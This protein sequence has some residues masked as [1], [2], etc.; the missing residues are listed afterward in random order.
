M[1][2]MTSMTS[3]TLLRLP[4]LAASLLALPGCLALDGHAER[5]F[6]AQEKAPASVVVE[7]RFLDVR[8]T[9]AEAGDVDV[10]A[11]VVL[12]TTGGNPTAEREIE[13]CLVRVEREGDV[14]YVRQ[15]T[16]GE[17]IGVSS[18]SGRGYVAVILPKGV[19]V[20]VTS[21]SGDVNLRGD[22]GAVPIAIDVASGDVDGAFSAGRLS[23]D[24]A[25]GDTRVAI[26]G[27]LAALECDT[28][29]GDID[30]KAPS[31]AKATL[32]AASGDIAVRG[33]AGPCK[34]S[35]ASGDIQLVFVDYP[36]GAATSVE[37]ASGDILVLL[38]A[39]AAPSGS[40]ET[41]SGAIETTFPAT[42]GRRG[43]T[44]TGAGPALK[45]SAASGDVKV[46][47]EKR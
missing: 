40:I 25:S 43:A 34:A 41:A 38:P 44:F 45:A 11:H 18:W 12:E 1:P 19:P 22:F 29:S 3:A 30:V 36:A 23:I 2:S 33:L 24:S 6:A 17:R 46:L 15:G 27:T 31:I 16:K 5:T 13:K 37:T 32:S 14:L 4:A 20:T 42:K 10:D 26:E 47:T 9:A 28:A 39:Q 21:A 7:S 35:A 8:L